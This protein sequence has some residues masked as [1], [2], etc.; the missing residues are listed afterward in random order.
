[1]WVV[2]IDKEKMIIHEIGHTLRLRDVFND[3]LITENPVKSNQRCSSG[4]GHERHNKENEKV[5]NNQGNY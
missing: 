3:G 2:S 1:M 4:A 5:C